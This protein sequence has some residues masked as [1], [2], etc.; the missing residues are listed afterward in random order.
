[1]TSRDRYLPL[2]L[3][4]S[5]VTIAPAARALPPR[6]DHVVVVTLENIN[7][8]ET[9][10]SAS[11]PYLNMLATQG[12]VL[13]NAYAFIHTSAPNYGELFAGS[14]N[15][16]LDNVIPPAPFTTPNLAAELRLNGYSFTG[17]AQSMPSIGYT[18]LTSGAYTRGHNPWVN[19]QNDSANATPNQIPSSIN[20]PFTYFPTTAVGFAQLPTVSFVTPDNDN[21]MHNGSTLAQRLSN[22]DNFIKNNLSAYY[23]WA[24]T[25]NSLLIITAD[26]D[27][28][29]LPA[30]N[31]NQIPAIF[32]GANVRPGATVSSSYTLHNTLRT[33]EDM[34]ALPH[35]ADANNSRPITGVFTGDPTVNIST[36]Q[37]GTSGYTAARD[38]QIRADAP[39]TAYG[40]TNPLTVDLDTSATIHS[41]IRFDN[42]IGVATGQIPSDATVLSA[43]LKLW[44]LASTGNTTNPVEVHRM[45]KD[46]TTSATWASIGNGVHPDDVTAAATPDFAYAPKVAGEPFFFDVSDSLQKW[47]DGAPNYG[48]ALLP[49]G[50]DDYTFQS[51]E[52]ATLAQR[53]LLEVSYALYPRFTAAAGSWSTAANW[54]NGLPNSPAAVARFL[55][56]P[57]SASITLDGDKTVGS[58]IFDSPGAYTI[59]P[60][61]GGNLNL[62]NYGNVADITVNQ[63]THTLAIPL[64]IVDPT[65]V[66]IAANSRLNA[67]AVITVNPNATFTKRG[68]G[69]FSANADLFLAAG[70][71]AVTLE[72]ETRA[73]TIS[74]AGTL[75]IAAGATVTLTADTTAGSRITSLLLDGAPDAWTAKLDIGTSGFVLDYTGASPKLTLA[76]QIKF[77]RTAGWS[78]NGIASTS[79][80]ADPTRAIGI[81]EASSLLGLSDA[82]TAP[83]L[84][85]SADATSL[86][87]RLTL[88]GDATL[89]GAVD[90]L[91]LARLAQSYNTQPG[92]GSWSQGDFNYDGLVDFN[93]LAALAQNYNTGP[94][95][96]AGT[97]PA[98]FQAAWAQAQSQVPEPST[99]CL[100]IAAC[101]AMTLHRRR[102]RISRGT[103]SLCN[104]K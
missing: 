10:G 80:A 82:A 87:V 89:D 57:T 29:S 42:L 46:W 25:H 41:L 5:A 66:T 15:G 65:Q 74:G 92:P 48:W 35:A 31:Y 9:I 90:F 69:V 98:D 94:A 77:A 67:D 91:D 45:L 34:Y 49:T 43:K 18:G 86:L 36:F 72:G 85:Q 26:E 55:T 32:A 21:N 101:T 83:F 54:A 63:G 103:R 27:D 3:A 78:G 14:D 23:D 102:R 50:A 93:D 22:G 97:F 39:T 79:A 20:L 73:R 58:I 33:I 17:Y 13:S 70:A 11:T 64:N 16:I 37:N 6:Y 104:A 75:A 51:A 53:P 76:N 12:T 8:D 62:A 68:T 1:M 71:A 60:G 84:G 40:N 2:L 30:G 44:T 47:L 99:F 100:A 28:R 7:G 52:A 88:L 61:T 81:G 95:A 59:T 96:A 19:W 24:K 38:T 4:C 56:R